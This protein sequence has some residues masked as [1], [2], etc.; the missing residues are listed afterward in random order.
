MYA[1]GVR[2]ISEAVRAAVASKRDPWERLEAAAVAHL[3]AMLQ[4]SDYAQV[5]VRVRPADVP[6]GAA[7][8]SCATSTRGCSR[9]RRGRCRWRAGPTGDGCG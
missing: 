5:V 7:G 6:V 1:E 3:E 2:Q 8:R 9:A 4:E